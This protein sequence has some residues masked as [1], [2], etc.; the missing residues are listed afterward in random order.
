MMRSER[1]MVERRCAIEM[2]VLLPFSSAARAELTSVSDS[3]S[4]AEVA[5]EVECGLVM[6]CLLGKG[7]RGKRYLR[8][9]SVCLDS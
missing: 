8:R 9:G 6:C 1:L 3:A 7:V 5:V 2:V 4:S